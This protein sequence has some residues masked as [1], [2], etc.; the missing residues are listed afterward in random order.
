MRTKQVLNKSRGFTLLELMVSLTIMVII[1]SIAGFSRL[2]FDKSIFLTNL[3]YDIAIAIRTA[4]VYGTEVKSVSSGVYNKAYG[5]NFDKSRPDSFRL[6]IDG[7]NSR[8]YDATSDTVY[9]IYSI[10][11]KNSISGLC[12]ISDDDTN[13]PPACTET[14]ILDVTFFRPD[15]AACINPNIRI[16]SWGIK[17]AECTALTG[18]IQ[19]QITVQSADGNTKKIYIYSTGQIS[20]SP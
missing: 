5:V 18:K 20:L 4:Q 3:T 12:T 1:T 11:N 15:P 10:K 13:N 8:S 2:Q 14:N 19:A 7:N 17:T 16:M 6:F 9:R